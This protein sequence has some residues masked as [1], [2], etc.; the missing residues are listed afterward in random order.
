MV[1]ELV[2]TYGELEADSS[3]RSDEALKFVLEQMDRMP[4]IVRCAINILTLCFVISSLLQN[5][6]APVN[7]GPAP[8]A[9]QKQ[10]HIWS[11]STF[12][13]FRDLVKF[14][15]AMVVLSLYSNSSATDREGS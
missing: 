14:Y 15:A 6:F 11:S 13:P 2:A 5:R 8:S 10:L 9:L 12:R 7:G 3:A 1:H 4:W